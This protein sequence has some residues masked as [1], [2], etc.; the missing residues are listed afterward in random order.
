[1]GHFIL[2]KQ[3]YN[4]EDKLQGETIKL[5]TLLSSPNY[6]GGYRIGKQTTGYFQFNLTHKPKW[7]HRQFMRILLGWY[8]FD[9]K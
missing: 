8:W 7:L 9:A 4:M 6:V 3:I 2:K 5:N 1:M